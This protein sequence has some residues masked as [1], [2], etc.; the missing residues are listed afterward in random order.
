M[1]NVALTGSS[2][3]FFPQASGTT[4][5]SLTIPSMTNG[6]LLVPL[7]TVG[8]ITS[9][10]FNGV[11]L[12]SAQPGLSVNFGYYYLVNPP[13]GTYTLA[14]TRSAGATNIDCNA[15]YLSNV[16]Q[17]TPIGARV[18]S[19]RSGTRLAAALAITHQESMVIGYIKYSNFMGD[20]DGPF[21]SLITPNATTPTYG[22]STSS[23]TLIEY[24]TG[25]AGGVREYGWTSAQSESGLNVDWI[26][27]RSNSAPAHA[28][29]NMLSMFM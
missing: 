18:C 6:L 1:A 27:I 16:N 24:Y 4:N 3:D 14:V 25:Q 9:V 21:T 2:A 29:G 13:T 19:T 23:P 22:G 10:T 15:L 17:T 12:K 20:A 8:N 11:A 7:A 26:E 28:G 5:T